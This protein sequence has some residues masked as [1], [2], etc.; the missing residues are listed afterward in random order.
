VEW[1]WKLRPETSPNVNNDGGI[2]LPSEVFRGILRDAL[3]RG[4]CV[5][6]E[7]RGV[8]MIPFIQD[9]DL[10]TVGPLRPEAVKTGD[11]VAFPRPEAGMGRVAVHRVVQVLPTGLVVRGDAAFKPDGVIPFEQVIGSISK[12]EHEGREVRRG[13]GPER[14]LLGLLSRRGLLI[15]LMA[16]Y[17]RLRAAWKKFT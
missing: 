7:A 2:T 6:F 13:F 4:D 11:L 16:R 14:R 3:A 12:V 15:P 9:G 10:V 5:R 8:S 17:R 1:S